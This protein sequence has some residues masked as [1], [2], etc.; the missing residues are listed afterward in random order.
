MEG[1]LNSKIVTVLL[2]F[3]MASM[4]FVVIQNPLGNTANAQTTTSTI[5]SNLLQYEWTSICNGPERS[6]FNPGPA[7]TSANILWKTDIPNTGVPPTAFGGLVFVQDASLYYS[8][9]GSTYALD[10]GTGQIVWKAQGLFG[11][12]VKLDDTYMMIG[13]TCVITATGKVAW[14]GPKGFSQSETFTGISYIPEL[15]MFMSAASAWSLPDPSKPPTLAWSIPSNQQIYGAYSPILYGN[16]V[17]VMSTSDNF[18]VGVNA[19]TGDT[20]WTA[21]GT[22]GLSYGCSFVDGMLV[23][24]GLDGNMK[25]WNIVTGELMWTFNPGTYYNEFASATATAYGLVYEKNQDTYLYAVNATNGHLV[26]KV[27]GP[28][29]GYSNTITVGGGYVYAQMGDNQYRDPATGVFGTSEFDCFNAL[30][31]QL[32]WTMPMEDGSPFN[33]QCLAYGNLYVCPT[34]SS[35]TPGVWTYAGS[36]GGSGSI[37]EVW[38]ISN[39]VQGWPMFL[40]DAAH[41]A[42][43][44]GP[45]NLTVKWSVTSGAGIVSSPTLVNGVCYFGSE[46]TNVY[47]VD[48]NTGSKMWTFKTNTPVLS[49]VAVVGGKLYT[50]ADDGNIYCLDASTGTKLWETPA[51]GYIL[52]SPFEGGYVRSSPMVVGNNVYVGALDGNL[53]CLDANSGAVNWKLQTGGP[54]YAT[55]SVV[56]NVVYVCPCTVGAGAL[57]ELN[58]ANGNV[59]LNVTVPYSNK[60][61]TVGNVMVTAPTVADGMAFVRT[62]LYSN[63]AINATTGKTVWIYNATV[64]PGT[65]QQNGGA[66][67]VNA[68][69]YKYGLLYFS[70]FYGITCLNAQDGSMV[71]QTYLS[72][73]DISQGLSYSYGRIYS[74]NEAGVLYVLDSLTGAKLSYYVFGNQMHSIPT[75][76][77]GYLYV[78]GNNWALYCFGDSRL[79]SAAAVSPTVTPTP[80]TSATPTPA[81]GATASPSPTAT[82]TSTNYVPADTFYAVSAIIILLIVAVAVLVLRKK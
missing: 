60:S 69:L 77:N 68:M 52:E 4:V 45:T 37:G 79:M 48:A 55:P 74:V 9:S 57:L 40:G 30:T 62:G 32:V 31:G 42:Y 14:T 8:F 35:S 12:I 46:D 39:A 5:A 67:Q 54:I 56:D 2:T 19:T 71:W 17:V 18:L 64:N 66:G 58:A 51:G 21:A 47:A 53:Y 1:N 6:Y 82:I 43:G 61:M 36:V 75:P 27:K 7:P 26:W 28:G 10:G 65:P 23:F 15:K 34:V 59:I 76:Y 41:T 16:G 25:A 50:G 80:A 70:D 22:S 44:N 29:I 33:L 72:R 78:A 38:C 20:L 13:S 3:L 49:T 73:E 24:G 63:F 81:S 11:S